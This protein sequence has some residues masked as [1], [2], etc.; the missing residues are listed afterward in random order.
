MPTL[1]RVVE[2]FAEKDSTS[3]RGITFISGTSLRINEAQ[4]GFEVYGRLRKKYK[5]SSSIIDHTFNI[6]SST[7]QESSI[8]RKTL[9]REDLRFLQLESVLCDN[10]VFSQDIDKSG[11]HSVHEGG[12]FEIVK[13]IAT[14]SYSDDGDIS[15]DQSLVKSMSLEF[16]VPLAKE[17]RKYNKGNG[18]EHSLYSTHYKDVKSGH[19]EVCLLRGSVSFHDDY[20]N[21]DEVC[22][23][24]LLVDGIDL[25]SLDLALNSLFSLTGY[26]DSSLYASVPPIL[27]GDHSEAS[28]KL[29]R[30]NPLVL[31]VALFLLKVWFL[32]AMLVTTI[33]DF[34]LSD[35]FLYAEMAIGVEVKEVAKPVM[36][37][38]ITRENMLIRSIHEHK[39]S[40][41]YEITLFPPSNY[42]RDALK[43]TQI[44]WTLTLLTSIVA[45]IASLVWDIWSYRCA[46]SEIIDHKRPERQMLTM[47]VHAYNS[48]G[49]CGAVEEGMAMPFYGMPSTFVQAFHDGSP[50]LAI[51]A[52][53]VPLTIGLIIWRMLKL[54]WSIFKRLNKPFCIG[55][56]SAKERPPFIA[57]DM[58]TLIADK[59]SRSGLICG[60]LSQRKQFGCI[61]LDSSY[62]TCLIRCTCDGVVVS[63][64]KTGDSGVITT[65]WV[66]IEAVPDIDVYD[67][68]AMYMDAAGVINGAPLSPP[69]YCHP[70]HPTFR[71]VAPHPFL[72][73]TLLALQAPLQSLEW[74]MSDMSD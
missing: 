1:S 10:S 47:L 36:C 14:G 8:S 45:A 72:F 66:W 34:L 16:V 61:S 63:S 38:S 9:T 2:V 58:Y 60:F 41:V 18:E 7:L 28:Q 46:Q 69:C 23:Y 43:F 49:F 35:L 71:A 51:N 62:S 70:P 27:V 30:T 15:S 31:M 68:L 55:L 3:K 57:S 67:P 52:A 33:P 11:N 29:S 19:E 26:S 21:T 4:G 54:P 5:N 53:S 74:R 37:D 48:W 59:S 20:I 25:I 24:E 50:A 44:A 56:P 73:R 42:G 12:R 39:Q 64:G 32:I 13:I 65:D 17:V 40:P 6:S 22:E